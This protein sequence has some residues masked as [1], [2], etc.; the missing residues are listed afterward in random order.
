[1]GRCGNQETFA[2][3]FSCV[4][5]K[6]VMEL[7]VSLPFLQPRNDQ[8]SS[9][10]LFDLLAPP[11]PGSWC[12]DLLNLNLIFFNNRLATSPCLDQF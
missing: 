2:L 1:M 11:G 7:D 3:S 6:E 8:V 5:S 4:E 10:E 9:Q 12:L